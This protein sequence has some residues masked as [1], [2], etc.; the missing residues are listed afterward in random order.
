MGKNMMEN[1]GKKVYA[2]AG[3]LVTLVCGKCGAVRTERAEQYRNV[4]G[5]VEIQCPCG[6][7]YPVE[8]ELRQSYRKETRLEGIYTLP[9]GAWGKIVVK[10]ISRQGCGFETLP[11]NPLPPAEEI[12]IKFQLDDTRNSPI[13]KRVLV[14][15]RRRNYVGGE[16]LDP[17]GSFDPDLGFYLR[18]P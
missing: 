4:R 9:S 3:G 11:G 7:V 18:R 14:R 6:N 10:N 16:F 8:I 13:I 17:P 1:A 2:A 5:P 15:C 12:K